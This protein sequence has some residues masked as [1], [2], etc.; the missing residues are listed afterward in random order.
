MADEQGKRDRPKRYL[1]SFDATSVVLKKTTA[2]EPRRRLAFF[3]PRSTQL[4]RMTNAL[5]PRLVMRSTC[6]LGSPFRPLPSS[7]SRPPLF[8]SR[9]FSVSASA[10][11]I[12][13]TSARQEEKNPER[14]PIVEAEEAYEVEE[15]TPE[16]AVAVSEADAQPPIDFTEP[17]GITYPHQVYKG[18]VASGFYRLK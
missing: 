9:P 11:F 17:E 6:A 5:L 1:L 7:A 10:R 3:P 15:H 4:A 14:R 12:V 2:S 16:E 18:P 8:L 13:K